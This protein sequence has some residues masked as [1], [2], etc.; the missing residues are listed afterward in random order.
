MKGIPY[1]GGHCK[2][3]PNTECE[4]I[5]KNDIELICCENGEGITNNDYLNK[6]N[7]WSTSSWLGIGTLSMW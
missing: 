2:R 7:N 3:P 5:H 1:H 6:D 4:T